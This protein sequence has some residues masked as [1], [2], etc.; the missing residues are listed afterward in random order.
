MAQD[1][2]ERGLLMIEHVQ[3]IIDRL[4]DDLDL[5][6]MTRV[7]DDNPDESRISPSDPEWIDVDEIAGLDDLEF[8]TTPTKLL[9]C[10]ST[11]LETGETLGR[12]RTPN[13][14]S[15]LIKIYDYDESPKVSLVTPVHI[16]EEKE[17]GKTSSPVTDS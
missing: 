3:Q 16:K 11:Q 14:L 9:T 6:I 5:I 12:T 7:P 2:K 8:T 10:V 13:P 1:M 4:Q 17:S 15:E